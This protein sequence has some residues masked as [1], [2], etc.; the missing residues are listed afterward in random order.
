MPRSRG[1]PLSDDGI[2][3]VNVTSRLIS[4][5]FSCAVKSFHRYSSCYPNSDR[6]QQSFLLFGC[7]T[8]D[9]LSFVLFFY[10]KNAARLQTEYRKFYPDVDG[11]TFLQ[12]RHCAVS[13]HSRII[14]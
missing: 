2:N 11:V 6:E 9:V 3:V 7:A 1:R 14:S 10:W 13:I 12:P 8:A 5:V 4:R